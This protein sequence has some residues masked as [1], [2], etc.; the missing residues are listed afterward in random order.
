MKRFSPKTIKCILVGQQ[1]HI[2]DLSAQTNGMRRYLGLRLVN[3][4]WEPTNEPF[5]IEDR[6]EYRDEIALGNLKIVKESF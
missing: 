4:D 1:H 6:K 2:A 5:E 3:G